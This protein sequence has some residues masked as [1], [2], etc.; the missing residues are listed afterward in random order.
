[1]LLVIEAADGCPSI[2]YDTPV[3]CPKLG[4]IREQDHDRSLSTCWWIGVTLAYLGGASFELLQALF[5]AIKHLSLL[6]LKLA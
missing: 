3:V 5:E 6:I 4:T 1:M 2:F